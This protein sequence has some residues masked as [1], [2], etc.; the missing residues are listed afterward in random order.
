L[1]RFPAKKSVHFFHFVY[2]KFHFVVT[3]QFRGDLTMLLT[4]TQ[5]AS[6]NNDVYWIPL[7]MNGATQLLDTVKRVRTEDGS[8]KPIGVCMDE[9]NEAQALRLRLRL[10]M[11]GELF[12]DPTFRQRVDN[13]DTLRDALKG[14]VSKWRDE[15]VEPSGNFL[16]ELECLRMGTYVHS[17]R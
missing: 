16:D 12:G 9:S 6:Y 7:G 14:F 13:D 1:V 4:L 2:I 17:V 15:R 3:T 5:F 10:I 8:Y 11:M